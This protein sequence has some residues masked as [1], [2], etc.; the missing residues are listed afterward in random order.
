[1]TRQRPSATCQIIPASPVSIRARLRDRPF[2]QGIVAART[3]AFVA[4]F[5]ALSSAVRLLRFGSVLFDN[6]ITLY[7]ENIDF[8]HAT[9]FGVYDR[10][11]RML[12]VGHPAFA[13]RQALT[14]VSSPTTKE[15]VA[16]FGVSV[17]APARGMGAAAVFSN[18]SQCRYRYPLYMHCLSFNKVICRVCRFESSGAW[19]VIY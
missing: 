5:F 8:S 1:M 13:P 17:A 18:V 4:P 14:S 9:V 15:R 2:R 12:D 10:K 6:L 11:L 3:A 19:R 16:E 7:V